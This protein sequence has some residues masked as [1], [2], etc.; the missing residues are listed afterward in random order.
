MF[1]PLAIAMAAV[2]LLTPSQGQAAKVKVWHHHTP[3]HYEKAQLKHTVISNE[4]ALRLSRQLKPLTELQATH[5]WD[6]VEDKAGNLLVS[7]GD[8]GKIFRVSPTGKVTIAYTSTDS[9]ILCL[10]VAADGSVYAGT[11][12]TGLILHLAPNGTTS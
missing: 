2:L 7:T 1:R 6:V 5:V 4:G 8:E 9:Q 12:P 3:A 10:A 11:G